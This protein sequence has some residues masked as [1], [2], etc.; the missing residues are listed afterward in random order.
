MGGGGVKGD[1][2]H[3]DYA[4]MYIFMLHKVVIVVLNIFIFDSEPQDALHIL[5]YLENPD[6]RGQIPQDTSSF[7]GKLLLAVS[8]SYER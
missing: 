2:H 6:S 1:K 5:A 7:V 8:L 4:N 3:I